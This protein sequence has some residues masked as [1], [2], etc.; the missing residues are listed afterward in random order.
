[1]IGILFLGLGF[2]A[3]LQGQW[4]EPDFYASGHAIGETIT[5]GYII[6]SAFRVS[7]KRQ[8]TANVTIV[9]TSNNPD[10]VFSLDR[11]TRLTLTFTPLNWSKTQYV[12]YGALTDADYTDDITTV[13]FTAS[14][15]GFDGQTVT[16]TVT[17]LDVSIV[18]L[19]PEPWEIYEGVV[20]TSFQVR[21][22]Q[23]P[24][25]NMVL[26]VARYGN[27]PFMKIDTDPKTDGNQE[28]L[29]FTPTNWNVFQTVAV[30]R[31]RNFN[32]VKPGPVSLGVQMI[33]PNGASISVRLTVLNIKPELILS[34]DSLEV[35]EGGSR[36]FTVKLA[37]QPYLNVVHQ[38]DVK[39]ELA[40]PDNADVK[41]DVDPDTDGYQTTLTF[42]TDNWDEEQTVTV[43]TVEDEDSAPDTATIRLT[44]TGPDYDGVTGEV[45][46]TVNDNSKPG[47]LL[48]AKSLQVDEGGE[49]TFTV[50]LSTLPSAD[51]TVTLTQPSNT[52]VTLD[53][54]SLTFTADDWGQA[55]TVTVSALHDDDTLNDSAEI[56]LTA[57]G[58]EYDDAAGKAVDVTVTDDDVE[59]EV[60][61][62]V[63]DVDEGRSG[64]F[65]VKLAAA[66]PSDVTVKLAQDDDTPNT[67]VTLDKTTLTFTADNWDDEQTVTVRAAE[68]PDAADESAT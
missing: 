65:T 37:A 55:Q 56:S 64:T 63:L 8:P 61:A 21:L 20:D 39:V 41:V 49:N 22:H 9:V 43:T 67:D 3:P 32:V 19:Q 57:S 53:K 47:L 46:V 54:T 33:F 1:M 28:T 51:V 31:S 12:D 18:D 27:N 23:Q 6:F 48:S 15:G 26:T 44:A 5:E 35:T 36:T 60:S 24:S 38:P 52:D 62:T 45:E 42:T 10:S 25:Q 59:L 2:S 30:K 68:D 34:M 66:P 14:G 29:T 40:Q 58:G 11:Q 50:K 13:L 7:L 17:V 4:V 16:R